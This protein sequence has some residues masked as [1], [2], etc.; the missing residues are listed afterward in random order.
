[1]SAD[2]YTSYGAPFWICAKKLPDEPKDTVTAA[3]ED[4]PLYTLETVCRNQDGKRVIT[5]EAV[6]LWEPPAA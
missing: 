5:G 3:R 1:M 2:K 4:R 6:V